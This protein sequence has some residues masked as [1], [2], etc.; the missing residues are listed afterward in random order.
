LT[1]AEL[2]AVSP[3]EFVV[4]VDDGDLPAL[5]VRE[6]EFEQGYNL[7]NAYSCSMFIALCRREGVAVYRRP[8]QRTVTVCVKTTVSKH[9]A[10]WARF[11]RLSDQLDAQLSSTT[12]LFVLEYIEGGKL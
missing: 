7:R 2:P 4:G 11:L 1:E 6:S 9:N 5:G 10:L 8:R 3:L 12:Q